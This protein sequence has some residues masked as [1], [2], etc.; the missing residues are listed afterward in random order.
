MERDLIFGAPQI[1][2]QEFDRHSP[3]Y[4]V[5]THRHFAPAF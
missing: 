4:R 1:L 5:L 2:T 3:F